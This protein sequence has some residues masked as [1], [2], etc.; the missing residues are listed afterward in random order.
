[1]PVLAHDMQMIA[2]SHDNY[3]TKMN[4]YI[5]EIQN[6]KLTDFCQPDSLNR[7]TALTLRSMGSW[8]CRVQIWSCFCV[9]VTLSISLPAF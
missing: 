9:K 1:M 4:N 8:H 2:D 5:L 6:L 3:Y 7:V